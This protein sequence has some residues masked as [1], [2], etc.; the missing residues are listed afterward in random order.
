MGLTLLLPT[1][2]RPL[3]PELLSRN[4]TIP[5]NPLFSAGADATDS[6]ELLGFAPRSVGRALVRAI[7]SGMY[8]PAPNRA[9]E[10]SQQL[11]DEHP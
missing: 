3:V 9:A 6:L 10:E 2:Q 5:S 4:S 11:S 7:G 1:L 8:H